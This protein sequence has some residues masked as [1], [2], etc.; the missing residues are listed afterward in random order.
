MDYD[1]P[2]GQEI[3]PDYSSQGVKIRKKNSTHKTNL[4]GMSMGGYAGMMGG[5]MP[6]NG[7]NGT[8][9]FP[10]GIPGMSS[11]SSSSSSSCASSGTYSHSRS[12]EKTLSEV[13]QESKS[14]IMGGQARL[15]KM[16]GMTNDLD[17]Q[18]R[19]NRIVEDLLGIA[20]EVDYISEEYKTDEERKK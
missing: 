1:M 10:N 20:E 18:E 14:I 2:V 11:H 12:Q 4:G 7:A 5:G 8:P 15:R 13:G 3:V 17:L 16:M 9:N 19:L 6:P